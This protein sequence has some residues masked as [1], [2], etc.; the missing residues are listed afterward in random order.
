M[1]VSN[2]QAKSEL[3]TVQQA[4]TGM[5]LNWLDR[6]TMG[7][8]LGMSGETLRRR[9]KQAGTSWREVKRAERVRRLELELQAVG[10]IDP[11]QLAHECGFDQQMFFRFFLDVM[12][13]TWTEW[14]LRRQQEVIGEY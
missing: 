4:I 1:T 13:E 12:G 3:L 5:D 7:E 11:K 14:R 2:A 10:R 8:Y 9:L 6:D